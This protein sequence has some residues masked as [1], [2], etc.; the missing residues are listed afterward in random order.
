MASM[1]LFHLCPNQ[2]LKISPPIFPGSSTPTPL[3]HA[4]H[5]FSPPKAPGGFLDLST[6]PQFYSTPRPSPGLAGVPLASLKLPKK[7]VRSRVLLDRSGSAQGTPWPGLLT[8]TQAVSSSPLCLSQHD[9][10]A[11][12][13]PTAGLAVCL[14]VDI[15]QTFSG[16]PGPSPQSGPLLGASP[17]ATPSL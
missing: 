6:G 5:I 15:F 11:G 14:T 12:C 7:K 4:A 2:E 1:H 17:S 13:L 16:S 8:M 9:N 10:L 3:G